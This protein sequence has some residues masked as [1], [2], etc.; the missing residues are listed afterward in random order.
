MVIK[1]CQNIQQLPYSRDQLIPI[2]IEFQN[3]TD[4][5]IMH[6]NNHDNTAFK[7]N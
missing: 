7:R 1:N 5:Y 3:K 4:W 2:V 6:I